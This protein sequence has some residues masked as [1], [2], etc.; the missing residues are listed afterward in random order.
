[1]KGSIQNRDEFLSN[2]AGRLGRDLVT[3]G[4][5]RPKWKYSPQDAVLKDASSDEL[6]DVLKRQCGNILTDIVITN[7]I[8]L[9]GTINK[10]VANYGGGPILSWKDP[11][12]EEYGLS[13]LFN[14]RWP[15][16]GIEFQEWD[17]S[18]G[19][20]NI[21]RAERANIGITISDITLAESGTAVLFSGNDRGRTVS[22]L[23]TTSI[24]LIPKSTIVPRMTQAARMIREK[25]ERGEHIASCIN[26]ITG[27]SNSADIE[28]K[29]VVGVHGPVKAGYIVIED[30]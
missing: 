25:V 24:I 28:S 18:I 16:E 9:A 10:M 1:M 21:K 20:E 12:F 2:I 6:L 7:K 22:F 26:F 5:E 29:L 4:V 3:V 23:P 11:R 13:P 30:L 15:E 19:E 17:S 27:P 8:K 14:E